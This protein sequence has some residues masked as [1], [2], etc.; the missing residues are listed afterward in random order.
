M[1]CSDY[2][3]MNPGY[4]CLSFL[5]NLDENF[6]TDYLLALYQIQEY[7]YIRGKGNQKT[8]IQY[9]LGEI[10]TMKKGLLLPKISRFQHLSPTG[11]P[12]CI[13]VL[14]QPAI[15]QNFQDPYKKNDPSFNLFSFVIII[16]R[17]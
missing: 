5:L 3:C 15:T 12:G 14:P 9:K 10:I 6:L 4:K 17:V 1:I 8:Q 13:S 11:T 7:H 2:V 16:G